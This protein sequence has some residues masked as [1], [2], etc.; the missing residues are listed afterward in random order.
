MLTGGKSEVC[1]TE[2]HVKVHGHIEGQHFVKGLH[3]IIGVYPLEW[4]SP[5]SEPSRVIFRIN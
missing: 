1:S 3:Y 5:V 4:L 2:E